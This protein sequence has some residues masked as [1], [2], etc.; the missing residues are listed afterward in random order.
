MIA[1]QENGIW[2]RSLIDWLHTDLR[3]VDDYKTSGMSMAPHVIG[4]RAEAAGWHIQAA[5]IE[6]GLDA[7]DPQGAGRRRYRFIG[8]ET[9][10]PHALTV[11]HMNEYW[12][13]MGRKKV[14]AGMTCGARPSRQTG[15]T[16]ASRP[17][18]PSIPASRRSSGSTASSTASLSL[19]PK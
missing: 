11:M 18:S 7:L 14:E 4:G 6:R 10:K 9:D 19:T 17:W 8:Q 16:T 15:A 2:C 13:T 5:F 1:W 3:T 12:M